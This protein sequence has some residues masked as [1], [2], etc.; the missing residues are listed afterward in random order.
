MA[1]ADSNTMTITE[2]DYSSITLKFQ[3]VDLALRGLNQ[4]L[5]EEGNI[6]QLDIEAVKKI[7]SELHCEFLELKTNQ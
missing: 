2:A 4:M 6:D 7:Y 1:N 3:S 5:D